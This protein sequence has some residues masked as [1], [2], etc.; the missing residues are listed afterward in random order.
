MNKKQRNYVSSFAPKCTE[1]KKTNAKKYSSEYLQ[2]K[3]EYYESRNT[4]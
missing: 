2:Y 1:D 3:I 4:T